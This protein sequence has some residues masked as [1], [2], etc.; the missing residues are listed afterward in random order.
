MGELAEEPREPRADGDGSEQSGI[1][2]Y[3][4]V[5]MVLGVAVGLLAGHLALGIGIG[6]VLGVALGASV[7]AKR[8]GRQ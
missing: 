8:R 4:P 3:L 2:L 6:L 1:A 5:G 7:D